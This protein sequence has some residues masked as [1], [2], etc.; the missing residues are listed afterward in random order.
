MRTEYTIPSWIEDLDYFVAEPDPAGQAVH[1]FR[2]IVD[3]LAKDEM[4]ALL[5][6]QHKTR[7]DLFEVCRNELIPFLTKLYEETY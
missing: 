2:S 4:H 1:S 5:V 7:E 3:L 6:E